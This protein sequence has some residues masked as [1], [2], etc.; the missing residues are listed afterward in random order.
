MSLSVF[1]QAGIEEVESQGWP[2]GSAGF[3]A[4]RAAVAQAMRDD[5][6][7]DLADRLDELTPGATVP[8]SHRELASRLLR[9]Y[10]VARYGPAMVADLQQLI[11]FP[12]RALP[13]R[14]NWNAPEFL[15]QRDWL[16]RRSKDL[17]LEFRS[18]D[19][20]VEEISLP[21]PDRTLALLTH[22][23]V[24]GVEGQ[25]WSTPPWE[26]R[27]V[28]GRIIGRGAEDDKG[29]LV[30]CL[31][32]LAALGDSGWSLPW[33]VRLLIANG[34]E[35]SWK[36]IPYYLERAQV[37][38]IT[39]GIDASYPVTHSQ[40][41][42]GVLDVTA[43]GEAS[44]GRWQIVSWTG[45]SGLSIIPESGEVVVRDRT[46]DVGGV[47]DLQVAAE[48]WASEHPP[49][50]LQVVPEGDRIRVRAEGAGGHSSVPEGG[51]NA[52]GD[53]VAFLAGLD[54][55]LDDRGALV[56]FLGSEVGV[57]TDGS[58]LGIA[59]QDPV[60]GSLTVNLALL[61]EHEGA[62]RARLS[63]RVPRGI[64]DLELFTRIE[65]RVE[66]FGRRTGATAEFQ[67][68]I[69]SAPHLIPADD[70]LVTALLQ[71]WE[72]V[73]GT[74]GAPVAIGGG[75][76]VRLFPRGVDFGPALAME[77]YRGHGPDEYLTREELWRVAELTAAAVLAMQEVGRSTG[78]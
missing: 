35:S 43:K 78:S 8:A 9:R 3:A 54:L 38:E 61:E 69:L 23:D 50:R 34:E 40:K 5:G 56:K 47:A 63:V 31:Y 70:A 30:A 55:H 48:A 59:H 16:R 7:D 12:T 14:E 49:A 28:D 66:E 65:H 41:G 27:E 75:T 76:Q 1:L 46:A 73:T 26:G 18:V 53:L 24:Q 42:Y 17:G 15:E 51:H 36:E 32:V 67:W 6:H 57:E 21:G 62:G 39:L 25:T 22:G 71:V 2:P 11:R 19:G 13:G 64:S 77:R 58:T 60:M 45:G 72:E 4:F 37:P 74:P 44:D 52:L 29:P 10:V 68:Q 20:R 33:S